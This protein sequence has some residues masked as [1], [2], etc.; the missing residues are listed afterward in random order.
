MARDD[1]LSQYMRYMNPNLNR[2]P[3]LI[4]TNVGLARRNEQ[5]QLQ[6]FFLL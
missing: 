3:L 4:N 6:L 5:Q 2:H 1:S